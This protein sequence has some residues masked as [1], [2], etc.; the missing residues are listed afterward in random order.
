MTHD[1]VGTW[2]LAELLPDPGVMHS[3][4]TRIDG[5]LSG[6]CPLSLK[7]YRDSFKMSR[8]S[9]NLSKTE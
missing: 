5:V 3:C 2:A 1:C 9:A 6:A 4:S 7:G 8:A